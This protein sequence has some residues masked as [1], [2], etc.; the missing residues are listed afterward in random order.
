MNGLLKKFASQIKKPQKTQ[1]NNI[2]LHDLVNAINSKI[3]FLDDLKEAKQVYIH[4][5]IREVDKETFKTKRNL[6][7]NRDDGA[8]KK[9]KIN[10]FKT[11]TGSHER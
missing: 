9:K 11:K 3:Y 7:I 1:I 4:N 10:V 8:K 6:K 5:Q 2:N